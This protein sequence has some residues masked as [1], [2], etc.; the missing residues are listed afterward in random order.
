MS[1]NDGVF[2]EMVPESY[3]EEAVNNTSHV[4]DNFCEQALQE[5]FPKDIVEQA[6]AKATNCK[7]YEEFAE[8]I[9]RVLNDLDTADQREAQRR[10]D[11]QRSIQRTVQKLASQ[12]I[13]ALIDQKIQLTYKTTAVAALELT[14]ECAKTFTQEAAALYGNVAYA[15]YICMESAWVKQAMNA[16]FDK[17]ETSMDTKNFIGAFLKT[18]GATEDNMNSSIR[19]LP[20]YLPDAYKNETSPTLYKA[21]LS[22]QLMTRKTTDDE[23]DK[24]RILG[25]L[26][27]YKTLQQYYDKGTPFK[28]A[29]AIAT[30][31]ACKE[32]G[33]KTSYGY[34]VSMPYTG[35]VLFNAALDA[36]LGPLASEFHAPERKEEVSV[37]E[38]RLEQEIKTKEVEKPKIQVGSTPKQPVKKQPQ[39]KKVAVDIAPYIPKWFAA[40]FIHI[41]VCLILLIFT[42][43]FAILSAVAFVFASIGWFNVENGTDVG[44][45]SPYLYIA[46]GY[47]GFVA[48][49]ILYIR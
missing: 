23:I 15:V 7:S 14:E 34:T 49:M 12:D 11:V 5:G 17:W 33:I 18:K 31:A 29:C 28:A 13:M 16:C 30:Y 45:H 27:Y 24:R 25:C 10:A 40:T 43:F 21:Y 44:G 42:K 19:H 8:V 37:T 48:C 46:G 38:E 35:W 22:M 36:A 47:V 4:I 6:K 9:N 2:F 39:K 41:V 26:K 20:E 3:A 32:L 1:Q